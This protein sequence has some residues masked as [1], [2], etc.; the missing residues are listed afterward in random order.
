MQK[1]SKRWWKRRGQTENRR[2]ECIAKAMRSNEDE[3][4]LN[5]H[6]KAYWKRREAIEKTTYDHSNSAR[7][8]LN[9]SKKKAPEDIVRPDEETD[10]QLDSKDIPEKERMNTQA[11][12]AKGKDETRLEE[13]K[14][15]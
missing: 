5:T 10:K 12:V 14:E 1:K 13:S 11:R 2:I 4:E 15:Q 3:Y 7:T 9:E 8:K 6:D